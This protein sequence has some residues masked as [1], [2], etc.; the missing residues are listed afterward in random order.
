MMAHIHVACDGDWGEP[1]VQ[2]SGSAKD[3]ANFGAFLNS[4]AEPTTLEVPAL[5]SEFYP[6]SVKTIIIEPVES[7]DDRIIVTIDEDNFN[8][9][10]TKVALNKL[11]DSLIN[12]FDENSGVGEHFQLDYY[13]G[14]EVLNE[15]NC[16]LIFICDR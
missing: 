3:L 7:G 4:V 10:G 8:L 5:D 16:H 12:F 6:V 11:G 9:T 14:N 13:E 2:T 1:E 15:T